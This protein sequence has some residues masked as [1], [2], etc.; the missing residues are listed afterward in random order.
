M[1]LAIG[2][3]AWYSLTAGRESTDDAQVDAQ[4][5]PIAFRIPGTVLR[6]HIGDNKPVEAGAVLVELD[7]RDYEVAVAKARAELADAEATAAAAESGV[8]ITTTAAASNVST[9]QGSVEQS[10]GA[11][12]RRRRR[13]S[14]A[15]AIDHGAGAGSGSGGQRRQ[16]APRRRT[17]ARSAGEG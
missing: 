13:S 7:P 11:S 4:V 2:V 12:T 9:A 15:G 14:R 17:A 3:G 10:R 6:V 8:P 5:T 16:A 1:V